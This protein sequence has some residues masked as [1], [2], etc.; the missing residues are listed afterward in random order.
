MAKLYKGKYL[1]AF[2]DMDGEWP[3]AVFES[4]AEFAKATGRTLTAAASNL[5]HY[6][7]RKER[8]FG[9]KESGM[10]VNGVRALPFLIPVDEYAGKDKMI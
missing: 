2:Y 4:T 9:R 1:I 5:G 6:F 7:A 3:V 10:D 8:A